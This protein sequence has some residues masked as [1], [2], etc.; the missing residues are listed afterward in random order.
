MLADRYLAGEVISKA[1]WAALSELIQKWRLRL[2]DISWFMRCMNEHLAQRANAEDQC[3]GRFWEGRF[4]SQALLDD[5]A[6]LVPLPDFKGLDG[7]IVKYAIDIEPRPS[8][9]EIGPR[10]PDVCRQIES[11]GR[12]C[13]K[14]CFFLLPGQ[15]ALRLYPRM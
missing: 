8:Q 5:G 11:G 2:Y 10:I 6:L 4:K 9:I 3:K 15:L 13:R 1:E 12:C 14:W 7:C